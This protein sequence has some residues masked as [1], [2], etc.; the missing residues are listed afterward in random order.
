MNFDLAHGFHRQGNPAVSVPRYGEQTR[1]GYRAHFVN[2]V[3]PLLIGPLSVSRYG[4]RTRTG[5]R[6]HFVNNVIPLLI[7]PLSVS[8]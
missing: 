8:R 3:I 1:T 7:G 2:N 4:E 5:Y 6:T